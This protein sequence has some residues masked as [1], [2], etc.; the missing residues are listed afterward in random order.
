MLWIVEI[1]FV[2]RPPDYNSQRVNKLKD[3]A[4]PR[5]DKE[6]MVASL[7]DASERAWAGICAMDSDALGRALSD[8]MRAWADMLPYT[9]DP[10]LGDDDAKSRQ[11]REFWTA[12]DRPHTRGCLFS[13]AGGGFLM[14]ISDTPVKGGTQIKINTDPLCKPFPSHDLSS[15]PSPLP[16]C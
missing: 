2:S 5:E 14:V 11:L 7:A 10:Y 12:Y 16:P 13:G 6:R 8:T 4:V 9:V 3:P 15:G 1:P